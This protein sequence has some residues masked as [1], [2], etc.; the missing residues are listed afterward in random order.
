MEA[1]RLT[2][3][4]EERCSARR[5]AEKQALL[6]PFSPDYDSGCNIGG[7]NNSSDETPSLM[8]KIVSAS[9]GPCEGKRLL[10]GELSNDT[11]SGI[12]FTRDV[13]PFLRALLLAQQHPKDSGPGSNFDFANGT[14]RLD[15]L[16]NGMKRSNVRVLLGDA[17]T[18]TGS[19][20]D[21][22]N[23]EQSLENGNTRTQ[24]MNAVFGDPCPGV[25]KRLHVHY[26]V[27]EASANKSA[28]LASTEWHDESFAEHEA[29]VLKRRISCEMVDS[30]F[31]Y[32]AVRTLAKEQ[33]QKQLLSPLLE[34]TSKDNELDDQTTLLQARR[35][36][37]AQSMTEFA[38]DLLSS[39]IQFASTMSSNESEKATGASEA[40][41]GV[42][43]DKCWST[44]SRVTSLPPNL[45]V[46][47]KP[48]QWR[49]RSAVSEIV[50]P[51]VMPFLE[52]RERVHCQRVCH[53]WRCTIRE[54]G[55]ATTIDNNDS[56]FPYFTRTLLKGLL[57]NSYS[58]LECLFLSGFADLE[59]DDLHRA[60][61]FLRKLRSI[62]ISWC[63]RLNN[64]TMSSLATFAHDTL[65]VLYMK[66]VRKVDDSG[67]SQIC[68]QCHK[69]QVLDV[70]NLPL[71]DVSGLAIGRHLK[72]LRA[73]YMRDNYKL[74][75]ASLDAIT[76]HCTRLEQ[77]TLCGLNRIKHLRLP[78]LW[79]LENS[80]TIPLL[81]DGV[82]SGSPDGSRL[83]MLNLWGCHSL[84]DDAADALVGMHRL[85]SL[86]VSECHRLTDTFVFSIVRFV[87]ELQHLY[88]RYCKKLTDASI[89]A[90]TH[91]VPNLYSLDLSFCTKLSSG[92]IYAMLKARGSTLAELRLQS[93]RLLNI[94]HHPDLPVPEEGNNNL[95][96]RQILNALRYHGEG[97][98]LSVLDVRGCA[99]QPDIATP[100]HQ[101]DPFVLGMERLEFRQAVPG[102]FRRPARWNRNIESRLVQQVQA[103]DRT[104][105]SI[106]QSDES[107]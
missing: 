55:V 75:N 46:R 26:C 65:R 92:A 95:A 16:R 21:P 48:R 101:T 6:P 94:A 67:I 59:P 90:I 62:D 97:S 79:T 28:R 39:Y 70:S 11:A 71:T 84:R 91:G 47:P 5:I 50:L 66:G 68:R 63:V 56:A 82:N 14:I 83:V 103:L 61:P 45:K 32:A 7:A 89:Q 52:V 34:L 104:I 3:S 64:E 96:G 49:L 86:I 13:T 4:M 8:V 85:R 31:R 40:S 42:V 19:T 29:V 87:P 15:A 88:L 10:T 74:T 43:L 23:G 72:E 99:G 17:D 76:Q 53:G 30:H 57:T 51:I 27:A 107:K 69:L 2:M 80:P 18:T 12:P 78:E 33:H 20:S 81:Y 73:L 35:M 106:S 37:R 93:C 100:Y 54:W 44:S 41:N 24:S 25:S 105:A 36:G 9:Y 38:E 22:H 60:I 77:L 58:S 98:S 1:S 102:F